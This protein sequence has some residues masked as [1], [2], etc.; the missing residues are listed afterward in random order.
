MSPAVSIAPVARP[1]AKWAGGKTQLLPT[2][3]PLLLSALKK[4]PKARYHE[5][6]V[7]G[8]AVFFGLR[9]AGFTGQAM[10]SDVNVDLISVY[11]AL[12][13]RYTTDILADMLRIHE[14]R[15]SEEY[16]YQIR[17]WEINTPIYYN[18][19]IGRA[20]RMIYLNKTCF[21]GLYRVNKKGEFNVPWGKYKNPTICDVGNLIACHHALQ[22]AKVDSYDFRFVTAQVKKGDVVYFDP[23]YVPV[24]ATANFT[25]Y[26]A[27][28]FG[29]KDQDD[30][31]ALCRKLDKRRV[32]F[33]LSNADTLVVHDL[34]DGFR[35]R[36]VSA[37]RS[38]NSAGN[39]RGPVGELI[40]SNF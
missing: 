4:A 26:S 37:R 12:T 10:L 21:N 8:G 34:Y 39:K 23:P 29:P 2:I 7:G 40:V 14:K 24:S 32:K 5:P 13:D 15:N 6:F 18:T 1:F 25:G 35:L 28:G 3:V 22:G 33:V 17:K 36:E 16:F 27:G 30:L 38:V 20:A 11:R 19:P 31:A 9:A